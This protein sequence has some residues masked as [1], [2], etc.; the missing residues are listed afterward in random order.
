M[1]EYVE[2]ARFKLRNSVSDEEFLQAEESVRRG[3]L[4]K[5]PGFVSREVFKDEQGGWVVLLRFSDKE[6]MGKLLAS[7]KQALDE[8]FIK[9]GS[10]IDRETMRIDFMCRR[11]PS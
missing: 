4:A 7:L 11:C 1:S 3:P 8:S 5:F 10:L 6:S 9:Y 2:L